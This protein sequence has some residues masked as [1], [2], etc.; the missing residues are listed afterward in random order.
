M[1]VTGLRESQS[2]YIHSV[3]KLHVESQMFAMVDCVTKIT[4]KKSCK[5]GDYGSFEHLLFFLSFFF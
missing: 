5:Y 2:L 4:T 1:M 3:V